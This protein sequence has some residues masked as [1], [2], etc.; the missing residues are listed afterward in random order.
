LIRFGETRR[1]YIGVRIQDVP[2]ELV[3]KLSL[4][5]NAHGAL[6]A[7]VIEGGPADRAGLKVGDVITS[8]DG[9]EVPN[10]RV[11]QRLVADAGVDREADTVIKRD[12]KDTTVKLRLARLE[13]A[14]KPEA[15][16]KPPANGEK[17]SSKLPS[18]TRLLG[19]D[20]APLTGD[21]RRR[22]R[23]DDTVEAGVVVMSVQPDSALKNTN[24]K[25]GDVITELGDKRIRG[26]DDLSSGLAALKSQGQVSVLALVAR[27]DGSV[28]YLRVP[29]E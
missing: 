11:L 21:L 14:E 16:D 5:T 22:F 8:F 17:D 28:H 27:A 29:T 24:L 6:I 2:A 12:G 26:L 3:G 9:R 1:G 18:T 7:G 23:I 13:D 10:A 19:L 20:L 25:P 4:G 15:A